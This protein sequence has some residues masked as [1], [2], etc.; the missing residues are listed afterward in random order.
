MCSKEETSVVCYDKTVLEHR[1]GKLQ[2]KTKKEREMYKDAVDLKKL[3]KYMPT[4][5]T[6]RHTRTHLHASLKQG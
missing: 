2:D 6:K 4:A 5:M 3:E 1:L